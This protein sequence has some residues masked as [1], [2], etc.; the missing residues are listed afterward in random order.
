[1]THRLT[2][3]DEFGNVRESMNDEDREAVKKI[4]QA[5]KAKNDH[6][7][8][9]IDNG[10]NER[11]QNDDETTLIK[12]YQA[13]EYLIPKNEICDEKNK[14]LTVKGGYLYINDNM[15]V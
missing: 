6:K 10:N 3:S 12:K 4:I 7:V 13:Q 11:D 1:M 9:D 14:C 8:I 5:Q 2:Y 15:L